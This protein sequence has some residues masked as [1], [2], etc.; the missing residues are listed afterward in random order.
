VVA[1]LLAHT[2][3]VSGGGAQGNDLEGGEGGGGGGDN[4][5]VVIRAPPVSGLQSPVCI[6]VCVFI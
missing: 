5:F 1:A 4:A 2:C 3:I 6:H